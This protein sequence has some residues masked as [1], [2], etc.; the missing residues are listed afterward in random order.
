MIK[1]GKLLTAEQTLRL[2]VA[3]SVDRQKLL[4]GIVEG[5][6]KQ[7]KEAERRGPKR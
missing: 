6:R 7:A 3:G 1:G 4:K 2:A 5:M